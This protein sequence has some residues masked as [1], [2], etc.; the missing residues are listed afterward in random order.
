VACIAP[1]CGQQAQGKRPRPVIPSQRFAPPRQM[2]RS[3]LYEKWPRYLAGPSQKGSTILVGTTCIEG[4]RSLFHL[5]TLSQG[6]A[7]ARQRRSLLP[8]AAVRKNITSL[9]LRRRPFRPDTRRVIVELYRRRNLETP[10]AGLHKQIL[11]RDDGR[12]SIV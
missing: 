4:Q 2:M 8:R 9:L 6:F 10:G 3:V 1:S 11:T 7:L 5:V 12:L